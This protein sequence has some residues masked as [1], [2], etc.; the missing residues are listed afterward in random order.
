MWFGMGWLA[1]TTSGKRTTA[2]NTTRPSAVPTA[3][4][5]SVPNMPG[6]FSVSLCGLKCPP[7]SYSS[8]LY[9]LAPVR[10]GSVPS[11]SATRRTRA[12]SAGCHAGL[13]K[14]TLAASICQDLRNFSFTS[15]LL[16]L[17]YGA[18]VATLMRS[19]T[20]RSESGRP[21]TPTPSTTR[22]GIMGQ[23]EMHEKAGL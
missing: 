14:R 1:I 5:T 6:S 15:V 12:A 8:S 13:L 23:P 18:L 9:R 21:T 10:P 2:S 4:H 22:P 11:S 20:A 7:F 17:P 3:T 19:A 16:P